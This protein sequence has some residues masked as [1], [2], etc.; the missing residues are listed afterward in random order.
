MACRA[1]RVRVVGAEGFD[2]IDGQRRPDMEAILD[3][4]D[5]DDSPRSIDEA[6]RFVSATWRP[7]LYFEFDLAR[8]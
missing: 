2:I 6:E 7:G 4:E 1:A 8:P 3:L 5:L